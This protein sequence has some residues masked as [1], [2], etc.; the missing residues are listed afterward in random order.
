MRER[1][2]WMSKG[3]VEFDRP[4][5]SIDPEDIKMRL[6][7]GRTA[8][9]EIRI[10]SV[11]EVS[12]KGLAYSS[13][14]RVEVLKPQYMGKNIVIPWQIK[15]EYIDAETEIKGKFY[16]IYNGG[17]QALSFSFTGGPV[18]GEKRGDELP[19]RLEEFGEYVK[20]H[21]DD[22]F[23]LFV[24]SQFVHL[25]FMKNPTLRCLY[26]GLSKGKSKKQA[27]EEFLTGSGVKEPVRIT[28][29]DNQRRY[30]IP[31]QEFTDT[32]AIECTSWGYLRLKLWVDAPFVKLEK[33]EM[34]QEDFN[35][36]HLGILSYTI[37][38]QKLHSGYN[39]A[40]IHIEN[41]MQHLTVE[42][43]VSK[44]A[45]K[46]ENYL[47]SLEYQRHMH[48]YVELYL[49]YCGGLYEDS[50]I[51][52][53]M[54]TELARLRSAFRTSD[55]LELLHAELY[56]LQGKNDKAMLLLE[57]VKDRIQENRGEDIETYCLYLYIKAKM[58]NSQGQM[59]T[60]VSILNETYREGKETLPIYLML[61][62]CDPV[63]AD[64]PSLRISGAKALFK[65]GCNSPYLYLAALMAWE[66]QSELLKSLD[67]FE[68]QALL[69][70]AR[71]ANVS[72]ELALKAAGLSLSEKRFDLRI[73]RILSD[74]YEKYP[75]EKLILQAIC[76]Q[77]MRGDKRDEESFS[78]YE[79]AVEADIR[80]TGLFEYYLYALPEFPSKPLPMQVLLY[81]SY[82]N[83]LEGRV[84][85]RLYAYILSNFQKGDSLY[86]A[87]WEQIQEF[88]MEQLFAGA[89][90]EYLMCI[91]E[92]VIYE[93]MIDI[94]IAQTLP[95]IAYTKKFTI[96]SG[97]V[98][99]LVLCYEET[100]QEFVVPFRKSGKSRLTA[101]A[102]VYEDNCLALL[103][104]EAGRRYVGDEVV[105]EELSESGSLKEACLRCCQ[106][107]F[108]MRLRQCRSV[109]NKPRC[110]REDVELFLN[111]LKQEHIHDIFKEQLYLALL[112]Y[113]ESSDEEE[114]CDEAVLQMDKSILSRADRDR[115]GCVMIRRN[116]L[117][118]AAGLF[119]RYGFER[120][121]ASLLFRLAS[122]LILQQVYAKDPFLLQL[123]YYVF[124]EEKFDDVILEYL[125]EHYNGSSEDMFQILKTAIG[126]HAS[127][128]DMDERLLAQL[129]YT[130]CDTHLDEVFEAYN[131]RSSLDPM[132]TDA[133]L[134]L[135]CHSYFLGKGE[136]G[137]DLFSWLEKRQ[138]EARE[139]MP[140]ALVMMLAL[141]KYYSEKKELSQEQEKLGISYLENLHEKGYLFPYFKPL[142]LKL[143][144]HYSFCDH[145]ILE[146]HTQKDRQL[147]IHTCF[148]GENHWE[149]DEMKHMY[150]GCFVK[151]FLLF[152]D[153]TLTYR[154]FQQDVLGP[155]LLAE[156]QLKGDA[157]AGDDGMGRFT[158]LNRMMEDAGKEDYDKLME[159]MTDYGVKDELTKRLFP[160]R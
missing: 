118:E 99:H 121:S 86:D 152:S 18:Y 87:Y 69:Y 156:G 82:Q 85:A 62:R 40:V 21:Y 155:E 17:E 129:L 145:T 11:N 83:Q 138:M 76:V 53:E 5:L 66:E 108:M 101:Y 137:E 34:T 90:D 157:P 133:Y 54:Q 144:R 71:K 72:R 32:V 98:T 120:I 9:G 56:C 159:E 146:Y 6:P 117:E 24:S 122:R 92:H 25:A 150:E 13:D 20:E 60:L 55:F 109:L 59:N 116:H 95:D 31:E 84:K 50:L 142:A 4:K 78:W 107:H 100:D 103:Q 14:S 51:L 148:T 147:M 135:K 47:R 63:M 22:A 143:K 42:L 75:E 97:A 27:L 111:L 68:K 12:V 93:E 15:G 73:C 160:L 106:S 126:T 91:Y 43:T 130:D 128:Y 123:S 2:M 136:A 94:R 33:N 7:A 26:D 80:L 48:K 10:T 96:P 149:T 36:D 132:L 8:R 41:A 61:M 127:I 110:D 153:E 154:I 39:L 57:D 35:G 104:D 37:Q 114:K 119:S 131:R 64:N 74:L 88:S 139:N 30:Q 140:A 79:K 151:S 125:C 52:N 23:R 141:T 44:A 89:S 77:R 49:K 65:K 29:C 112:S 38:P 46:R 1:I 67:S 124:S 70:G 45:H 81:F 3:V 58:E 19:E 102:P 115:L 158:L 134:V 105:E 28:V 113:Y 16:F